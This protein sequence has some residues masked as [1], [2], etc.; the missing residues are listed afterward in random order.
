M[1]GYGISKSLGRPIVQGS[2]LYLKGRSLGPRDR[3]QM[4]LQKPGVYRL[5]VRLVNNPFRIDPANPSSPLTS[6]IAVGG[7]NATTITVVR[8]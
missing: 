6:A 5:E 4:A 1:V 2:N 7:F 8:K 3:R